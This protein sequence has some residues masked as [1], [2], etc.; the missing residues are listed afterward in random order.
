[1]KP[2]HKGLAH[3]LQERPLSFKT[4]VKSLEFLKTIEPEIGQMDG[5]WQDEMTR[6]AIQLAERSPTHF[7]FKR[8]DLGGNGMSLTQCKIILKEKRKREIYLEGLH[9]HINERIK[10][11][12]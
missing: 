2:Y 12:N 11:K 3:V 8:Q 5:F 4:L 10:R 1:M 9:K 6:A 7:G